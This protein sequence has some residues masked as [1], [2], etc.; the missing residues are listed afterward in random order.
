MYTIFNHMTHKLRVI[1][2]KQK[3]ITH[4]TFYLE[5]SSATSIY[6]KNYK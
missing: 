3:N 5:F 6:D 2:I 1:L 4:G